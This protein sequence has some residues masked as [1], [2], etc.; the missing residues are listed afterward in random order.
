M[1]AARMLT[2]ARVTAQVGMVV[3]VAETVD[4]TVAPAQRFARAT[5]MVVIDAAMVGEALTSTS[6]SAPV[7]ATCLNASGCGVGLLR[8]EAPIGG[9]ATERAS[10]TE[11]GVRQEAEAGND[12]A[13]PPASAATRR[14]VPPLRPSSPGGPFNAFGGLPV[15]AMWT[16]SV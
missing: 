9:G 5:E 10:T 14:S 15:R 12:A 3:C 6:T 13:W 16:R 11:H 7:T 2:W 4:V 1:N 8:R